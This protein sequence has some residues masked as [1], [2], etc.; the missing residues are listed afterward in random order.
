MEQT[1]VTPLSVTSSA[2][3]H[4]GGFMAQV[5]GWMTMGLLLT[6]VVAY[7]VT[8]F[9]GF[10]W[11]YNPTVFLIILILELII[12]VGI[13]AFSHKLHPLIAGSLFLIY[14]LI[15]GV[16]FGAVVYGYTQASVFTAF[17]ATAGTFMIMSIYGLVTKAD[18]TSWGNLAFMGLIGLIFGLMINIFFPT[19][20]LTTILTFVGIVIFVILIAYDTQKLKQLAQ[21][22]ENEGAVA[23]YAIR[24]AL[25]LYLDFV[26]LFIRLLSIFGRRR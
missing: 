6:A 5:Y 2:L 18:L 26:N 12:V 13:S 16:F 7:A 14:A 10:Y 25:S 19:D 24:G 23:S 22:A 1:Q 8:E 20:F 9:E 11:L 15:N 3:A 17:A 4:L 21:M